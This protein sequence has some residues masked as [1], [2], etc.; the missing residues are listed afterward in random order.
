M[1]TKVQIFETGPNISH[2]SELRCDRVI[3]KMEHAEAEELLDSD[4]VVH[5]KNKKKK[6]KHR[7]SLQ[8]PKQILAF[9][10]SE[11]LKLDEHKAEASKC[12]TGS[13]KTLSKSSS[14]SINATLKVI[15]PV[16]ESSGDSEDLKEYGMSSSPVKKIPMLTQAASLPLKSALRG[17]FEELGNGP[18][19]KL[20]VKWAPS[21]WEPPCSTISH[22][23]VKNHSKKDTKHG[24][25]GKSSRDDLHK[26]HNKRNPH[27]AKCNSGS[28]MLMRHGVSPK[29]GGKE[30]KNPMLV[31]ISSSESAILM[32]SSSRE[33]VDFE[34][35]ATDNS[36]ANRELAKK[37]ISGDVAD[38][39][40]G[41]ICSLQFALES[42]CGGSLFGSERVSSC[43]FLYGQ[44]L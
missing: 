29:D 41:A 32:R 28:S 38:Q 43:N 39:G 44:T 18:R 35:K 25:K 42:T 4:S 3:D 12:V 23:L 20:H 21:V 11:L 37:Q 8:S 9:N 17:S 24:Y 26:K 1:E 10:T 6:K 16:I 30:V 33:L 13:S 22:T 15:C 7:G 19:P 40:P 34:S 14:F 27:K 31:D 2:F 5:E 36:D